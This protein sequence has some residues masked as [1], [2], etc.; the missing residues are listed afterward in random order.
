MLLVL[1]SPGTG[2]SELSVVQKTST[3][4]DNCKCQSHAS[5]KH[6]VVPWH[7]AGYQAALEGTC[8]EKTLRAWTKIQENV[9]ARVKKI[10][11]VDTQ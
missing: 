8:Q 7:D 9:L 4:T 3:Y 2:D 5:L 1:Y 6:S 11:P 10:G